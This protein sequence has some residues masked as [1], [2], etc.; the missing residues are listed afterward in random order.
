M[1]TIIEKALS[2]AVSYRDYRNYISEQIS[3]DTNREENAL[4]QYTVLNNSRM[5]R[6]D[7]TFQLDD[8]AKNT[9][10]KLSKP[11]LWLVITEGWCGDAA[12]IVP[13][14]D[15]IAAASPAIDLYFVY[16]DRNEDLMNLFLT[17]SKKAIPKLLALDKD[18]LE[19]VFTWGPRPEPARDMVSKQLETNGSLSADFKIELQQW[20]NTDR[21]ASIVNEILSLL[22]VAY[23]V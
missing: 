4:L 22:R 23:P 5:K 18:T 8:E 15:K 14:L 13:V 17:N 2:Q 21:G 1:N 16:R 9:L 11:M 7:K 12:Q 3:T 19:V 20:Y 10:E 6:L